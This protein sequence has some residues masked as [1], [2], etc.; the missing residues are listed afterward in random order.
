M[1]AKA[2]WVATAGVVTALGVAALLRQ[3]LTARI[4]PPPPAA[5][6][7]VPLQPAAP[8]AS[9]SAPSPRPPLTPPTRDGTGL[10]EVRVVSAQDQRP[11]AGAMVAIIRE[12]VDLANPLES[13]LT[14]EQ[15][16]ARFPAALP[17]HFHLCARGAGHGEDCVP[18]VG[19]VAG[20]TITAH[21]ALPPGA[22]VTGQVLKLDGTPAQGVRL[23][24]RGERSVEKWMP[25]QAITDAQGH[26]RLDGVSPGPVYIHPFSHEGQGLG[27]D[28]DVKAGEEARLDI[29]FAGFTT[30]TVQPSRSRNRRWSRFKKS[31]NV[32]VIESVSVGVPLR[33]QDDGGWTGNVEVG[34]HTAHVSGVHGWSTL[35][36]WKKVELAP[37]VPLSIKVPYD[38]NVH[39]VTIGPPHPPVPHYFELAGHVLMPDGTPAKGARIS[40]MKPTQYWRGCSQSPRYFSQIRFE[41]SAFVVNPVMGT[42]T[43]HAWLDDGRA[44]SV[45]VTATEGQRVV[46]DIRLED[47][48][49]VVG[50]VDV[51]QEGT[52]VVG[53]RLNVD[54]WLYH[55]M[56]F[57]GA[58]GRF[59]VAGLPPGDHFLTMEGSLDK[60]PFVIEGGAR[61]DLGHLK[62]DTLARTP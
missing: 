25:T 54:D 28:L 29:Q 19:L 20:G 14:D 5:V 26:Y 45:T 37:G 59:I 47:T 15:G 36:G 48:G 12:P 32:D 27:R 52:Y 62:A 22:T 8:H 51:T 41:G 17:G 9:P 43:V 3:E 1:R 46:A 38:S 40:V 4:R 13:A 49:A 16:L 53:P 11:L 10:A 44:G 57:R 42:Q 35:D 60:R 2:G 7:P 34:S 24:A 30:V 50:H 6:T 21:L 33:R 61:T 55:P 31:N 18:D 58:D 23:M 39:G 56:S